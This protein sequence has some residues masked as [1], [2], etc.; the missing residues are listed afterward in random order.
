MLIISAAVA[1]AAGCVYFNQLYNANRLFE[2]GR[3]DVESGRTG[4]GQA[5][6][7]TAISKAERIVQNNPNSRWADDALRLIVRSRILRGEWEEAAAAGEQLLTYARNHEDSVEV[8]GYLGTAKLYLGEIATADSLLSVALTADPDDE[9]RASLYLNRG[10]A[11]AAL[12]RQDEAD[13][14]FAA[15]SALR[16]KWVEPRLDRVRLLVGLRRSEQAAAE[17]AALFDLPLNEAEER[18]VINLVDFLAASSPETGVAALTDVE[19]SSLRPEDR[20][21]LVKMRGDMKIEI[22]RTEEGLADYRLAV[23]MAPESLSA[24]EAEAAIIKRRLT[25]TRVPEELEAPRTMMVR[26]SRIPAFRSSQEAS[27]LRDM[28]I[29]MD[30]WISSGALGYMLAAEAARDELE[31]PVLARRL[32]LTYADAEPA[33]LWVP[34]AILAAL[35]LTDLDSD[36]PSA[37]ELRQRLLEEYGQSAYVQAITGGAGAQFTYEDLE[38]G[39]RLQL[40]RLQRLA[41]QEVRART[42]ESFN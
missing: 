26:L 5:S 1:T 31:A 30:F 3:S 34:K 13:A 22:G 14:D 33:A 9:V 36:A 32:F 39:L 12:R 25:T 37:D 20:A 29:R 40:Q 24:V 2:Q 8:A 28:L 41:D 4:S 16:P 15:A 11:R 18:Q 35:E 42:V 23:S 6:L 27:R 21:R 19:S 38:Q 10:R 7:A 17:M